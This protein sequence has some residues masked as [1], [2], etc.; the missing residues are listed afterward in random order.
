MQVTEVERRLLA[1]HQAAVELP[2]QWMQQLQKFPTYE[3]VFNHT[4]VALEPL[5][6]EIRF[7]LQ[8]LH[9]ATA[10]VSALSLFCVQM[11]KTFFCELIMCG[12]H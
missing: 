2:P 10:N 11:T 4:Q 6:N 5:Q 7:L 1:L 9:D 8:T 3:E 12:Q